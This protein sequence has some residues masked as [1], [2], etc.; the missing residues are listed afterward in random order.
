MYLDVC[1][2]KEHLYG[3]LWICF[4]MYFS[5]HQHFIIFTYAQFKIT[6]VKLT[7]WKPRKIK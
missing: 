1:I 2:R 3:I 5:K 4:V 6:M 7:R